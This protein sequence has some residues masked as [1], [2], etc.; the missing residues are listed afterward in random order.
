M[1]PADMRS[2]GRTPYLLLAAVFFLCSRLAVLPFQPPATDVGIYAEYAQEMEL[3]SREGRSFYEV[4]A[5]AR[6]QSD[7]A[8]RLAGTGEEYRLVEYPPLALQ[9][10]RLPVLWM[11]AATDDEFAAA[12]AVAYR[13]GLAAVDV[14]LFSVIVWLV[15][16]VYPAEPPPQQSLRLVF[17]TLATLTLW[18]LLYDRL[19]LI[20]ALFV[21]LALALLIGHRHYG[22]SFLLLALAINFK[23]V[24]LVLAPVWIVGSLPADGQPMLSVRTAVRLAARGFLLAGLTLGVFGP[25]FL[26]AGS[27]ALGFLPYHRT[28]GLEI[29]S[30]WSCF[31]LLLQMCGQPIEIAYSYGSF[32]VHSWL[33]PLL[34][35]LAPPVTA[36]LLLGATVI[37]LVRAKEMLPTAGTLAQRHPADFIGAAL[38]FQMLFIASNKVFSP[39]YLLWLLPLAALTPYQGRPRRRFLAAFLLVCILT[40]VLMPFLFSFDLLDAGSGQTASVR[41]PPTTRFV[42]VLLLRN[43]L[44]LGLTA[45]LAGHLVRRWAQGP[46]GVI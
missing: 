40:T 14:L 23:L 17:Y 34:L 44:F 3:A 10:M 41:G 28:R 9:V 39:Q 5:T 2:S 7:A 38:L 22:W 6:Q 19:D 16:R 32:N 43:L 33:T 13:R 42:I 45:A 11:G 1:Q 25:F 12:Y 15:G 36:A 20:Q 30:V 46:P 24:P 27:D 31:P 29:E 21:T 8:G 4:H 37:L 35:G 18:H 26:S